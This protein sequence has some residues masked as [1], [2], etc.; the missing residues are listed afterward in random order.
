MGEAPKL[1]GLGGPRTT[2]A[3]DDGL[4][5]SWDAF[6]D[7][8]RAAGHETLAAA[9]SEGDAADGLVQLGQLLEVALRWYLRGADPDRPRFMEIN[10]TPE[11]A[12]NLFAA[13]RGDAVYRI[14]GDVSTLFDINVSVHS[15]WAWLKPSRPSGDLG[16]AELGVGADGRVEL[17]LGGEPRPGNWLP[18]PADA[19][20]IQLREYHADYGSHRPGLWSIERIGGDAPLPARASA[21]DV[22]G[23][24]AG[25]LSWAQRYSSFHRAALGFTFPEAQNTMR[26]PAT[27]PGGNS[28]IWYGFGRFALRD[29]QALILEFDAPDARLW[30]VQWLLDPWYENPDLLNRPTGITGAEAH[31]DGD[32]RVRVVFAA[33]DPGAPNWLDVGG[34]ERGLFVTRWIWCE[35]GPPTSLSVVSSSEL[36]AR[37]PADTPVVTPEQRAAQLLRRRTHFVH[38]RR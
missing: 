16:L 32:G 36:R 29:D 24:L 25:A 34:Y 27:N 5:G 14:T 19:A 33:R 7:G 22:A 10:D 2:V 30:S 17:V 11:V 6:C 12:D 37:L 31:V 8:L 18:L 21:R 15:S 35:H 9:S 26:P 1:D 28:H 38:R 3:S 13:V 20:F 23:R 4:A